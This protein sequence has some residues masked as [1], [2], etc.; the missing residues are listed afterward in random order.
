MLVVLCPLTQLFDSF[1]IFLSPRHG[2]QCTVYIHTI[3]KYGV[4]PFP[5]TQSLLEFP[6]LGPL[7]SQA[8]LWNVATRSRRASEHLTRGLT[9]WRRPMC[10]G[11]R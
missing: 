11:P 9:T 10:E 4:P 7:Q 8:R 6:D 5:S 2:K 1:I 3:S